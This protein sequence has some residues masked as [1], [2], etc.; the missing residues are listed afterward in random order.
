MKLILNFV[1]IIIYFFVTICGNAV[2]VSINCEKDAVVGIICHFATSTIEKGHQTNITSTTPKYEDEKI[3]FVEIALKNHSEHLPLDIGVHFEAIENLLIQFSSLKYLQR[4]HF[5]TIKKIEV[6][7]LIYNEIESIPNDVFHDLENL[8]HVDLANNKIKSL[9][10]SL[11]SNSLNLIIF[12]APNN[13]ITEI[14][15]D[16]FINNKKVR[17]IDFFNNKIEQ[18]NVNVK[19]R[20][21]EVMK[22]LTY[23]NLFGNS[24]KCSL[25]Y[26]A[27]NDTEKIVDNSKNFDLNYFQYEI[28]DFCSLKRTQNCEE[29][30]N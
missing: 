15:L 30:L 17:K 13:E 2:P 8:R 29:I 18:F 5:E 19:K 1:L 12:Y 21:T 23:F 11:L 9:S 24:K 3:Y 28:C 14:P 25:F 10:E 27:G 20:F 6:L 22:S 4:F 26:D 16:F 7:S